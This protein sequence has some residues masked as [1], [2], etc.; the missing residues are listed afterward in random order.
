MI[1]VPISNT[2]AQASR[3][4]LE[5]FFLELG[6][7]YEG[8]YR[9]WCQALLKMHPYLPETPYALEIGVGPTLYTTIPLVRYFRNI[10]LTDYVEDSMAEIRLWLLKDPSA[11]DWTLCI[12]LVLQTEGLPVTKEAVEERETLLRQSITLL[13]GCNLREYWVLGKPQDPQYDL[14]TAH[15]CTETAVSTSDEWKQ[16]AQNMIRLVRPGGWLLLSLSTHLEF[17]NWVY[18]TEP[19]IPPVPISIDWIK[20]C[21]FECGINP[22]DFQYEYL[23]APDGRPYAGTLMIIARKS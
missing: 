7:E 5:N 9:F 17:K 21:L 15:Y 20:P 18:D 8:L 23:P 6:E 22:K 1:D 11:F 2:V 16:V 13:S 10:H 4:Y 3:Q 14:V 19:A 12:R